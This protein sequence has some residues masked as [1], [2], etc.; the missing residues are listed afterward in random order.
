MEAAEAGVVVVVGVEGAGPGSVAALM[1]T[2]EAGV[3]LAL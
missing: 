2:A 3:H 1:G